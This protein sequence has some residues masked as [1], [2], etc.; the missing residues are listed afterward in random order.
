M[1]LDTFALLAL[2]INA[3]AQ[4]LCAPGRAVR[5][6]DVNGVRAQLGV[7][8][9]LFYPQYDEMKD[10][11]EVPRGR[12]VPAVY[13]KSLWVSGVVEGEPRA[14]GAYFDPPA[15]RPGPLNASGDT[16]ADCRAHDRIWVVSAAD[17]AAYERTGIPTADLAEWPH[18]LGAP[19][20]DGDG[21]PANY[22]LAGGDRPA[23]SGDQTA[24]WV[25]NDAAV[26]YSQSNSPPFPLEVRVEAFAKVWPEP[27]IHYATFYR[28]RLTYRGDASLDSAYVGFFIEADIGGGYDDFI[29]SDSTLGLAFAYNADNDDEDGGAGG[30]GLS[31]PAQGFMFVQGPSTLALEERRHGLAHAITYFIDGPFTYDEPRTPR[32]FQRVL[33][34]LWSNGEPVTVGG[35]GWGGDMPTRFVYSGQPGSFWSEGCPEPS[36][37]SSGYGGV[38]WLVLSTGPF[39]MEPGQEET[40]TLALVW[41]RGTDHLDSV[42]EL[43][44]SARYVRT[45]YDLGVFDPVPLAPVP[46]ALPGGLEVER[47]APNPFTDRAVVRY[48]LPGEARVRLAVY[49]ALGREVAVLAEGEREAGPHEAALDGTGLP[50]GVYFARFAV[51]GS[52]AAVLPLTRR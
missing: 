16:P 32:E 18:E 9:D 44:Q 10:G 38:A 30:Y 48:A 45:A 42:D 22:D 36:C 28:Y 46:P 51:N 2:S 37:T 33:S 11:Y 15:F 52:T 29:G 34:G 13:S 50:P 43:K 23:I 8:G 27:A 26:P 25:M 7:N 40:V 4:E 49:D 3:N 35:Y 1:R 5:Y 14:A 6:L 17:I 31:P 20:L 41:A 12:G 24:F 21:G 39:R 19:V 47:P